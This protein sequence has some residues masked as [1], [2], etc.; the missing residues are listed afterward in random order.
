MNALNPCGDNV[1]RHW[2]VSSNSEVPLSL[3]CGET[4]LVQAMGRV[5]GPSRCAAPMVAVG[6]TH[7]NLNFQQPVD[8][9]LSAA[10]GHVAAVTTGTQSYKIDFAGH[11]G[12]TQLMP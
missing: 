2:S 12:R 7:A 11:S 9:S 5:A 4:R 6:G 3:V 1:S 10:G 8:T